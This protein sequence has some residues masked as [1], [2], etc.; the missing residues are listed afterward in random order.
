MECLRFIYNE[1]Y[2]HILY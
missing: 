1:K 2:E